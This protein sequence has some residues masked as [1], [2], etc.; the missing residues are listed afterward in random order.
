MDPDVPKK[1][2]HAELSITQQGSTSRRWRMR[3]VSCAI[4]WTLSKGEAKSKGKAEPDVPSHSQ[5][6]AEVDVQSRG[7]WSLAGAPL[8]CSIAV[9]SWTARLLCSPFLCSGGSQLELMFKSP[10][11]S[12]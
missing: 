7:S 10:S 12:S 2:K 8:T 5:I 11:V 3:K 9:L 6:D 4:T 1:E